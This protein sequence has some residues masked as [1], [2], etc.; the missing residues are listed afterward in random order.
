MTT[1]FLN[2]KLYTGHEAI[3]LNKI[4]CLNYKSFSFYSFVESGK[5]ILK[6][7]HIIWI[8]GA[9]FFLFYWGSA[10]KNLSSNLFIILIMWFWGI[11]S[12]IQSLPVDY[13]T[14][15]KCPTCQGLASTCEYA[16]LSPLVVV[17]AGD[18]VVAVALA[19]SHSSMEVQ[20]L[21]SEG[22]D[23]QTE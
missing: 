8:V 11:I 18:D 4:L 3:P 20:L 17:S 19:V 5:K 23:S 22:I 7:F 16:V 6:Y 15:S 14:S 21:C 1:T 2:I 12:W 10:D 13:V 9:V